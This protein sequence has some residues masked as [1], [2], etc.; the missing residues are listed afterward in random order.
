[1]ATNLKIKKLVYGCGAIDEELLNVIE[2]NNLSMIC[3]KDMNILMPEEDW[4]QLKQVAPLA[5]DDFIE[6]N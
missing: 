1:M 5:I 2:D 4:E 6:I 3:D